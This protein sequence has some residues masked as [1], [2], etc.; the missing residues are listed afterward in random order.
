MDSPKYSLDI[1]IVNWNSGRLMRECL[2]SMP[3]AL[4]PGVNL[5]RVIVVDNASTDGSAQKLNVSGLP[6][7][8][9]R[10]KENKGFAAAS[11]QGAD[12]G[13]GEFILF[14]NPD[15]RL[16]PDSLK[17]P[18]TFISQPDNATF[19]IVGVQLVDECGAISRTCARFPT[20]GLMFRDILG[21]D[22]LFPRLF[23]GFRMCDWDHETSREVNHVMGSFFLVRRAAFEALGG[24]DEQFFMYLEDLDFSYR[25][26]EAGWRS[27]YL[28]EAQVH[29]QGGGTSQQIR[30]R[31]LFY[32]LR[33]RILYGYK[34]FGPWSA[35]GLMLSTILLEPWPRVALSIIHLSQREVLATVMGYWLLWQDLP[36]IC[37]TAWK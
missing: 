36:T 32:A 20:P 30:A 1:V 29:H 16:F 13:D 12:A 37:R 34:H 3:N 25:A 11:N 35:T 15:T 27:F 5:K 17:R 23:P 6:L 33:S 28:A 14:L 8:T 9:I 26:R 24:F 18:L 7:V 31:R 4:G 22:R 21:L 19:A 10:N 2:A